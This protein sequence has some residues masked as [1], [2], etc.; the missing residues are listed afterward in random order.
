MPEER[1][2]KTLKTVPGWRR[3]YVPFPSYLL[4]HNLPV[5]KFILNAGWKNKTETIS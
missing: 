3:S 1:S 5:E 2:V 4:N